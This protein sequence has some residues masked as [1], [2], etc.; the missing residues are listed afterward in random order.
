MTE[1]GG[2]PEGRKD[3]VSCECLLAHIMETAAPSAA[4]LRESTVGVAH[5]DV[6][7]SFVLLS[8]C[9]TTPRLPHGIGSLW[10]VSQSESGHRGAGRLGREGRKEREMHM[11]KRNLAKEASATAAWTEDRDSLA[12]LS[13]HPRLLS[14]HSQND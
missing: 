3:S 4:T 13:E 5:V 2:T 6:A 11:K 7:G 8:V 12:P 9:T 10:F 14:W 1:G